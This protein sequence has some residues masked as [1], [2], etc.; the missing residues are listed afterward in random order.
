MVY[1]IAHTDR[2]HQKYRLILTQLEDS[3]DFGLKI[4]LYTA[5][6]LFSIA[7]PRQVSGATSELNFCEVIPRARPRL[8][9]VRL[10]V[11]C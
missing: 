3:F 5:F 6:D 4:N 10:R 1:T 2:P 9:G 8:A 11:L 7:W